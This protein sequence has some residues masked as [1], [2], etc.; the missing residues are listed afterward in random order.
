MREQNSLYRE[1]LIALTHQV[2][3]TKL[4]TPSPIFAPPPLPRKYTA[5]DVSVVT[6]EMREAQQLVEQQRV[7]APW[8][9]D[10]PAPDAIPPS[11]SGDGVAAPTS[12]S[13]SP[14]PDSL[15][16]PSQPRP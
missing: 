4:T 8:Q 13:A 12:P 3:T 10:A 16:P 9:A 1:L 11:S 15:V 6:R 14:Q 2:P 7:A 5:D